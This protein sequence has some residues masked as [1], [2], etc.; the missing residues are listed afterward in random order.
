MYQIKYVHYYLRDNYKYKVYHFKTTIYGFNSIQYAGIQLWKSLTVNFKTLHNINAFK[1]CLDNCSVSNQCVLLC[2]SYCW[3]DYF[4]DHHIPAWYRH[5]GSCFIEH[6]I[7]KAVNSVVD[8][9][10][11]IFFLHFNKGIN[12]KHQHFLLLCMY[13]NKPTIYGM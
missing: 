13:L 2:L 1:R 4:L 9:V 10:Q 8:M 6:T 3:T 7:G 11:Y 12:S 5:I